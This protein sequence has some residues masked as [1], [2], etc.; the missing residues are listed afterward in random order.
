[1]FVAI[2]IMSSQNFDCGWPPRIFTTYDVIDVML[3]LH[4]GGG[5]CCHISNNLWVVAEKICVALHPLVS[6]SW[7]MLA[8]VLSNWVENIWYKSSN[9]VLI[10][11]KWCLYLLVHCLQ[12]NAK[13]LKILNTISTLYVN[14]RKIRSYIEATHAIAHTKQCM[15]EIVG[16]SLHQFWAKWKW[17]VKIQKHNSKIGAHLMCMTRT[18]LTIVLISFLWMRGG[19]IV[20]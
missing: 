3:S 1:M 9:N 11:A 7:G 17:K 8:Y 12:T 10:R 15:L 5:E 13:M 19:P 6:Y 18:T 4:L 14:N 20:A 16:Q 2:T